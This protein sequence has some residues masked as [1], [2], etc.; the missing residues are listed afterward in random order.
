VQEALGLARRA[1]LPQD[2]FALAA[3]SSLKSP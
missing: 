3:P 2:L 1:R